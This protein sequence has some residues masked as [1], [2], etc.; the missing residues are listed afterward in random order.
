MRVLIADDDQRLG[1]VLVRGM[2]GDSINA[3]L[4]A[5]GREAISRATA[6]E[7]AVI[8]TEV[9]LPDVDGFQVCRTIRAEHVDAPILILS[10]RSSI[11]DRIHG[12][13]A[14]ADDYVAKPFSLRE[15]LARLRAM[16]RRGPIQR[17][18]VLES[19]DLRLDARRHQVHRGETPID[20]SRTE[21]ALLEALMRDPGRVLSRYALLEQ[22]WGGCAEPR[23]NVVEV[24]VRY[25][26]EKIDRPF[27]RS[28]LQ[29]VRGVGYRICGDS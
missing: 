4:V 26:R 13:D 20:L 23:S 11:E 9:T 12:L 18:V 24:Y 2:A 5:S 14:G 29:T 16:S 25:L 27:G 22:A 17:G 8:I 7:Y 10:K 1:P 15:L 3:D 28:S 19:G 6:N 21:F